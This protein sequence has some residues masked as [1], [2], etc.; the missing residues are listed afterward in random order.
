MERA[1]WG[2]FSIIEG[3]MLVEVKT[4]REDPRASATT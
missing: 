3:N 4:R 1:K 2:R